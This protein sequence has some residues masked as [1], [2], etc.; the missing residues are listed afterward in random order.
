MHF[1]NIKK[2]LKEKRKELA[3]AEKEAL[4]TGQNFQIQKLKNE[5]SG[6]GFKGQRC[7]GVHRVVETQ[8]IFTTGPLNDCERTPFKSFGHQVDNGILAM[9]R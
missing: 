8:S 1:G 2:M 7:F 9:M 6:Y 3:E 4:G 5:I